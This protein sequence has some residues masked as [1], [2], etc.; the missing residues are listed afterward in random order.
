MAAR[1]RTSARPRPLT[2]ATS[3]PGIAIRRS[4]ARRVAS[5]MAASSGRST[6]GARVPSKSSSSTSRPFRFQASAQ[7]GTRSSAWGSIVI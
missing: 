5:G 6:M 4:S 1:S 3:T 2:T 7:P